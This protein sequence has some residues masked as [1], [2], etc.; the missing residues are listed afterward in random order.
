MQQQAGSRWPRR[1]L[2]AALTITLLGSILIMMSQDDVFSYTDPRLNN[3][4]E[5]QGSGTHVVDIDKGCF[6][7]IALQE[8]SDFEVVLTKLD[9]SARV[10]DSL[11]NKDC[12]VD[13]QAMDGDNSAFK[14]IASWQINQSAEYALDIECSTA[15]N[16]QQQTGWLVSIDEIQY[17]MFGSKSLIFGGSMCLVGL[18]LVPLSAILM[19]AN[20]SKG[21]GKLMMVN[22]D[23]TLIPIQYNDQVMMQQNNSNL[24]AQQGIGNGVAGPFADSDN[25]INNQQTISSPFADNGIGQQQDDSFVDASDDV[26]SGRMMTTD[27]VYSLM[28]GDVE[29]ASEFLQDPF[30][31]AKLQPT[32]DEKKQQMLQQENNLQISSWDEGRPN[33]PASDSLT[34][35]PIRSKRA[36][37]T[38]LKN[39]SKTDSDE[40]SWKQWDEM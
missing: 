18:L 40:N 30:V 4:V 23:G 32:E 19:A 31:S 26:R 5:F 28:R 1:L 29:G 22:Q 24:E 35:Q 25:A 6:R 11:Q 36:T 34:T 10:G 20:R 13:F 16:C 21:K 33:P 9:G 8:E 37:V 2:V 3:E 38:P 27:Q 15:D 17:G 14:I 12:L 39:E 7:V